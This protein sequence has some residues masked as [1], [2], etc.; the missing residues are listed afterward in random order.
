MWY[1]LNIYHTNYMQ[2]LALE[3]MTLKML[4]INNVNVLTHSYGKSVM[5]ITIIH[6]ATVKQKFCIAAWP[7]K[8]KHLKIT[9]N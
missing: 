4:E 8:D 7:I 5:H 1:L 2:I 9:T 6:K 3:I